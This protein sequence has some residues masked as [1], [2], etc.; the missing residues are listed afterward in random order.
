MIVEILL[1]TIILIFLAFASYSD[2]KT[3]EVPDLLNFSL[4]AVAIAIRIIATAVTSDINYII[5]GL[6]GLIIMI[7]LGYLMFYA[8]QWGGGDSKMLMGIGAAL[9]IPLSIQKLPILLIFLINLLFMGA[10]YGL[11][12]S[13]ILAIK[14]HKKFLKEFKKRTKDKVFKKISR[15]TKI[16][17]I[18]VVI[19]SIIFIKQTIVLWMIITLILIIHMSIYMI[20]FVKSVEHSAMFKMIDPKNLTPGEWIAKNYY[21]NKKRICGPKDLGIE[22]KQIK[23]LIEM[24]SK[25]KIKKVKIK[26]GIP[27]IPSFL[28]AYILTLIIGAWW[29][30][31]I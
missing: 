4:I 10:I 27:F 21:D 20:I 19:L 1:F 7:A 8:G 6:S 23:K 28:L 3:R 13:I 9:G 2:L 24:K 17:S 18:L 12:Y 14:N 11:L 26:V 15:I 31:I 5:E 22:K 25:G 16:S 30:S 29:T